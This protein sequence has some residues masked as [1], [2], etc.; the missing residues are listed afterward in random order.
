MIEILTLILILY[1]F[2]TV[3][4]LE[5][6]MKGMKNTLDQIAQKVVISESFD[7]PE[8]KKLI[9]EGNDIQAIKRARELFGF[10]LLEGK[11]YVETLKTE[12]K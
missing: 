8:I 3:M 4:K 12:A 10:T 6:R 9:D 1:L 5:S 7:D 11:Q 2:S